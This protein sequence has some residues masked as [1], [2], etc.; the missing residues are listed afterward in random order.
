[1]HRIAKERDGKCLSTSYVNAHEKLKWQ[2]SSGHIWE[3]T[4]ANVKKGTWCFV[5]GHEKSTNMKKPKLQEMNRLAL[6]HDGQCLSSEYV[7]AK[8]KLNWKCN[9][10]HVWGATPD[11]V[12]RGSWC[13][14][15]GRKASRE[16][17]KAALEEMRQIATQNGGECLSESY[18]NNRTNLV[19]KCSLGHI[20][21]NSPGNIKK[22]QWCKTCGGLNK[23]T[24]DEM[25]QLADLKGGK[26]LSPE[27]INARTKLDW[28]CAKGHSWRATPN[29]VQR[30]A[31]CP[32]CSSNLGENICRYFFEKIFGKKFTKTRPDWLVNKRNFKMEIDGYCD[33]LKL[34]FEHQGKQHYEHVGFFHRSMTSLS[35]R[36]EDDVEKKRL[37]AEHGVLLLEVPSVLEILGVE[38][39][40]RFILGELQANNFR[41]VPESLEP[42]C[43]DFSAIYSEY[44]IDLFSVLK[45]I[46]SSKSGALLSSA[47][48]G[49][50][51]KLQWRC[52][53]NHTWEA[54][55]ASIIIGKWCRKCADKTEANRR[56]FMIQDAIKLAEQ[57]DGSCL[58]TVY[59]D[60]ASKLKW[61]C[62]QGHTWE[63]TYNNIQKGQ[64]C[65]ICFSGR[66]GESRRIPLTEIKE[67]AVAKGGRCLSNDYVNN[68]TK[69]VWECRQGHQWNATLGHIKRGQWCPHCANVCK[70]SVD[71]KRK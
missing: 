70:K 20:W 24:L 1:M 14:K 55:P 36:Q 63:A 37:C 66:R 41:E 52:K 26:C 53:E 69:L 15:C 47:Y 67:L 44:E 11:S 64:W 59:I 9:E 3:A 39:L 31:W 33:E 35:E 65:P 28:Q 4:S 8:T 17:L 34:G 50:N 54:P 16:E 29:Q 18:V 60:N 49:Y 7:D 48:L 27:Y 23:R 19:W 22:G 62:S 30:G 68:R 71:M 57:K 56:R 32:V 46:A 6:D 42:I 10:G 25:N 58:S 43:L 45:N 5:C 2:C 38:N 21:Q 13:P 51:T 40:Q 12:R 61:R